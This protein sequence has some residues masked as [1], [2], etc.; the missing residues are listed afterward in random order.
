MRR[1]SFAL[2]TEAVLARQ[3]TVT[4][5][6]GWNF[7]KPGDRIQPVKK[8]MGL[9]KGEKQEVFPLLIE[10]TGFRK[11]PLNAI[12]QADVIR[13]GFPDWSPQEFVEFLCQ[14]HGIKPDTILSRI[15]FKYV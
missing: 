15:E 11:E 6:M 14:K 12:D 3:K 9:K 1:M 7:L 4:R 5:R 10:V 2:T 13:E 8:C